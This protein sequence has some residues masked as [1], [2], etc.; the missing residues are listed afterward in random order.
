M[1]ATRQL[2]ELAK[3]IKKSGDEKEIKKAIKQYK[4]VTK[5][6]KTAPIVAE[7]AMIG[8]EILEE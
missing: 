8:L 3:I 5:S 7:S 2:V 1:Y 4:A 6:K